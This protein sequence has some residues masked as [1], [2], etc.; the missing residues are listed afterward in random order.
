MHDDVR[1]D[2]LALAGRDGVAVRAGALPLHA[3]L[4]AVLAGDDRDLVR[5]HE[6]GIEAHAE[7]ADDGQIVALS[8]F[9]LVFEVQRAGLRDHAEIVLALLRAHADAVVAHGQ[10]ARFLVGDH[11]D[12][13]IV[14]AQP[15]LVVGQREIAEFVDRVRGVGDDLAQ[16][17]LLV[18]VDRVDHQIQQTLRFGLEL[19][20]GHR[21]V[22]LQLT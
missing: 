17:D 18:R 5:D 15:D 11:V 7:L 4:L 3:A 9:H 14:A 10:G 12:V 19:F 1:A 20:F 21:L 13:K 16:E 8:L 2:A 22:C 6:G